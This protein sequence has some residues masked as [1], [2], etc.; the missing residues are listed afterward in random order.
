MV[1]I[2]DFNVHPWNVRFPQDITASSESVLNFSLLSESLSAFKYQT[3]DVLSG[4]SFMIFNFGLFEQE[5]EQ[6][7]CSEPFQDY[8][9]IALIDFRKES[10]TP[11]SRLRACGV[12]GIKFHS[13]FQH[14]EEKDFPR[15]LEI[16]KIAEKEGMFICV[17]T[18]Y[19]TSGMYR[20]DNMKLACL[21]AEEI[22][23]PI[24]LLHSGGARILEAMLL[25][26][27][28]P[29]VF[30]E[31]SFS[32]PYYEGSSVEDDI[33]F[34]YRKLG[35]SRLIFGSDYPY[36]DLKESQKVALRYF[37][38]CGFSKED[39]EAIMFENGHAL[40]NRP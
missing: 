18:S 29:N 6:V 37:G 19:G 31:T 27:D 13:Y 14:I 8:S 28:K 1:K 2:F 17:D 39:V 12:R 3:K 11:F 38:R 20:F 24:I 25:A 30:L 33:V 34:T 32:L 16:S 35:A 26:E 15:I 23:C 40:V 9:F 10:L 5:A 4:A 36:V 21:L 22:S 7:F